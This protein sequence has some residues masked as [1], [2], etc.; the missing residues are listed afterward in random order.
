MRR[1]PMV[2]TTMGGNQARYTVRLESEL[3]EP[4]IPANM[5]RMRMLRTIAD[6]P[7]LQMC[8]FYPF[9]K[10]SMRHTGE[11]WIIELEASGPE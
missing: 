6:T 4:G 9:Q 10:F 8:G 3:C 5:E 1:Q 2:K 7:D 11:M